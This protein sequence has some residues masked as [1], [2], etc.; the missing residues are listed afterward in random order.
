MAELKIPVDWLLAAESP[1]VRLQAHRVLLDDDEGSE[2]KALLAHP[3][4]RRLAS[5]ALT[6][7][8][9][10]TGDH[11]AAKDL[12][13]KLPVLAD[14]GVRA[15]D[16][17]LRAL[18]DRI[19]AHRDADGVPLGH[20]VMPKKKTAEWLFDV[21]G[22]DPLLAL[23]SLGHGEDPRVVAAIDALAGRA[24][25]GGG[26]TWPDARSPL[27][28]RRFVGGCPYPTLKMLRILAQ[29]PKWHDSRVTRDGTRLLLDLW[30]G[31]GDE[32]R[33]GFGFG[34]RFLSLRYPFIGFDVLHFLEAL[35]PFPWVWKDA[36]F[37]LALAIVAGKA[38][39]AGRFTSESVWME[40]KALCFGQK[41][42]P[43]PWL[44]LV[45]HRILSRA[46]RR[47]RVTSR[48]EEKTR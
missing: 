1:W 34:D 25:D 12:L 39:A 32:R 42:E 48:R 3:L 20:V 22:Q 4:V 11:R 33:Y 35:S 44:T 2:R 36:R 41:R 16:L 46:P 30:E 37:Q 14:F 23:V 38:D 26:W 31:R 40:W 19:F 8:G 28:C 15:I 18:P 45:V 10:S 17:G 13:N 7:P 43:S 21:D 9:N 47:A 29:S 6:W 24:V 27:P 5:D